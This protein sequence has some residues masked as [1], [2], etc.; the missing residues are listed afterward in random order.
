MLLQIAQE[1]VV[2]YRCSLET[3]QVDDACTPSLQC[4]DQDLQERLES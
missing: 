3:I 2:P 1:A 4:I